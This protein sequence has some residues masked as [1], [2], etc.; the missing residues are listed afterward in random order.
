[1][2]RPPLQLLGLLVLI[3]PV[4]PSCVYTDITTPLDIDLQD[5]DLGDKIGRSK[6]QSVCGLVAW[7]DAGTQAAAKNGGIT[8]LK[9]A[10]QE[11]MVILFGLYTRQTTIVYGK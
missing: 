8:T 11:T 6:Y 10:D 9:H 1:M 4:L 7:G 3:L 2:K 5:T